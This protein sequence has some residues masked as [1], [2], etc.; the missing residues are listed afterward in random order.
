[1]RRLSAVAATLAT[2]ATM[3]AVSA[4]ALARD[5]LSNHPPS[6]AAFAWLPSAPDSGADITLTGTA[7]DADGDALAYRWDLD[8]DG[9]FETAGRVVR[10]RLGRGKRKLPLLVSDLGGASASASHD[11]TV[12]NGA[13]VGTFSWGPSTPHSGDDIT[14]GATAADPDGDAVSYSWDLDDNGTFE[15]S[16]AS[17]HAR[18]NRGERRV[19]LRVTDSSGAS[20]TTI[21]A[22]D[23]ADALPRGEIAIASDD[24]LRSGD[25]V[26]FSAVSVN[27]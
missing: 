19:R 10:T 27:D 6:G 16:G 14:L 18:F 23:V 25:T 3:L 24:D 2:A 11:I 17:A 8:D 9:T 21:Q 4:P 26:P 15:R 22:I 13:P 5:G 7:S 12:A 20:T 1:M